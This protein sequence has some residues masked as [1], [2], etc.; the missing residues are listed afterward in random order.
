MY[1]YNLTN[2]TLKFAQVIPNGVIVKLSYEPYA[3]VE[4]NDSGT[5]TYLVKVP[6]DRDIP[7]LWHDVHREAKGIYRFVVRELDVLK[8]WDYHVSAV[9][10]QIDSPACINPVEQL[11]I[12]QDKTIVFN[13]PSPL[14]SQ[15]FI[16]S[17]SE[18]DIIAVASAN[19]STQSGLIKTSS[20]KFDLDGAHSSDLRLTDSAGVEI[21]KATNFGFC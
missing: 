7:S 10:P 8:P 18:L 12:T 14:A 9:V 21:T 3:D 20:A 4:E 16:Y 5:R 6:E 13:F 17:D 2:D 11:S 1:A 19:S 15:R